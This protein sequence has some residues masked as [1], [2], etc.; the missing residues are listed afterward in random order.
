[1]ATRRGFMT[2]LTGTIV[3]L[4]ARPISRI[5]AQEAGPPGKESAP[6]APDSVGAYT[7]AT[8][9]VIIAL[10]DAKDLKKV[11]GSETLKVGDQRILLV[12][13]S[14]ETV[15]AFSAACTH[16]QV[17]LKYDH[18]NHRL[19]CPAHGSRFG[20]DGRVLRGPAKDPLPT[21]HAE[22]SGDKIILSLGEPAAPTEKHSTTE[23]ELGSGSDQ[24]SA[25]AK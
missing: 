18:K 7:G 21:Y 9:K 13:D 20:L 1:M 23:S 25:G 15:L 16:R 14:A 2:T 22:L 5:A 17:G 3:A 4:V 12:R 10:D 19:N 6:S 11:G 8:Q 24:G